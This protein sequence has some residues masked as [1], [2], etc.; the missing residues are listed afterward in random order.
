MSQQRVDARLA[1]A[2][3]D[4]QFHRLARAAVFSLVATFGAASQEEF[5]QWESPHVHPLELG[6]GGT[7][8][9]AVNTPDARL[10]VFDVSG[11]TPV[12]DFEVSVGLDPVSVRARTATEAW[13]VNHISDSVIQKAVKAAA[14]EGISVNAWLVRALARAVSTPP[15]VG[16]GPGKRMTGFTQT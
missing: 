3:I 9:L 10:A 16:R 6:V 12:L 4:E 7:T 1:A 13:V 2:E 5:V 14:R 15:T 8:L 11:G